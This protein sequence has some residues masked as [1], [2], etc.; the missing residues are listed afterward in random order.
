MWSSAV[1]IWRTSMNSTGL[2][3]GEGLKV[4]IDA[5]A[6]IREKGTV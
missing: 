3:L 4:E 6:R 1:A 2:A 5:I